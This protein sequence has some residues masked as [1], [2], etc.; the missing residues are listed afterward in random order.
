MRVL[1]LIDSLESGGAER[2]AVNYANSLSEKIAFSGL[3]ATRQ[4]GNLSNQISKKA[5]YL[6]LNK[7][8][9]LDVSSVFRLRTFVANNRITIIHAHG[10]S[11]FTAFLLKLVSFKIKIVW[12]DH[13]GNRIS[14][15]NSTNK[16]LQFCSFF[17]NSVLVVNKE[18]ESWAKKNLKSKSVKY[19]PN[20]TVQNESEIPTTFLK[21]NDGKRI[22][23]ISN[24]RDPKN[25]L[26]LIFSFA[27][28]KVFQQGWTLHL[29]GKDYKDAYSDKVKKAIFENEIQDFVY[30]YDSCS[31]IYLILKQAAIGILASS[32]EGFPVVLLEYGLAKLAVISTNVGYCGEIIEHNV[33]GF[34]FN[35][36]GDNLQYHL[37]N[38][39]SN[40]D[41]QKKF[42]N[43][44]SA[45]VIQNFSEQKIMEDIIKLYQ[46][47]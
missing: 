4:E 11:Y 36:E 5:H 25:H 32:Y 38:L 27:E 30:I 45:S 44:L 13:N 17:F 7:K 46:S 2:M 20:F 22:V 6:F 34:L 8:S 43:K 21:G 41:L 40:N 28:S 42:G 12:H 1:Q 19:T 16:I 10:T 47:L 3:V 24:L 15:K 29:I 18:L 9:T 14:E 23:C 35:P 37:K 26:K 33:S 39:T 31:D